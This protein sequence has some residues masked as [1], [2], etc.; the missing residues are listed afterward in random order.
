M[1][2]DSNADFNGHYLNGKT[3]TNKNYPGGKTQPAAKLGRAGTDKPHRQG[4]LLDIYVDQSF[5][6]WYVQI[7]NVYTF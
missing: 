3:E 1:S 4:L 5:I 6:F 7:N 2:K